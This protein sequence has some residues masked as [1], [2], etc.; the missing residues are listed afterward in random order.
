LDQDFDVS[1]YEII[2]VDDG[3]EENAVVLKGYVG[4]YPQI[5]YYRIAHSGLSLARNY[6][7]SVASGD[8]IYFCDSDDFVQPQVLRDIITVAEE[9]EL[10]MICA[11]SIRLESNRPTPTPRRNF[12][13]VSKTTSGIIFFPKFSSM[14]C[15]AL[16]YKAFFC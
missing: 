3:S 11:N 2:V 5:Q 9:R 7:L 13:I 15:M 1:E 16:F 6:G 8:W 14:G 12:N 10:E 4:Q